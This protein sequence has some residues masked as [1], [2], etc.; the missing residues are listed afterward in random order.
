VSATPGTID[1]ESITAVSATT[2]TLAE[3]TLYYVAVAST[4]ASIYHRSNESSFMTMSSSP[5]NSLRF[6]GSNDYVRIEDENALDL[7][8]TYTLEAW[9]KPEGFSSMA[10][11]ISKYQSNG[12]DGYFIRLS[13][14]APYTGIRFDEHETASGILSAGNWYHIAAVNNNGTRTLYVNGSPVS[15]SGEGY[16]TNSNSDPVRIGSDFG[17]RY[18]DGVIDEVRIWNVARTQQQIQDNM[19][20]PF[21]SAQSGLVAY[22]QLNANSGTI[23]QNH[24]TT[25]NGTLINFNFDENSGWVES[26]APLPVELTSFTAT[27]VRLNTELKWG[28]ATEINNHGFEIERTFLHDLNSEKKSSAAAKNWSSVGFVEGSGNSNAPKEYSFKDKVQKP[29]KYSYRLKQ[30]DRDGQFKYTQSVEIEVGTVPKVFALEQNYPNPFNPSTT[31]GFTLNATGKT[32]LKIYDAIGREVVT[33]VDEVLEAGVYHQQ[34]FNA[35]RFA[36]GVYF[37]RLVSGSNVQVKKLML[38][39]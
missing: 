23:A 15:I 33:L 36:S 12:A 19:N 29:G 1:Q 21:S 22:F 30:I 32:S 16:T 11:I 18:F 28:T 7:T 3:G 31:I 5:G 24:G 13:N 14:D 4:N 26:A 9:I 10:G 17:G 34:I 39:K 6:D 38:M 25:A 8:T 37:A 20:T 2:S 27:S 35:S